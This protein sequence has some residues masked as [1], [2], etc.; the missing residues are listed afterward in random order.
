M[1]VL[2]EQEAL[3]PFVRFVTAVRDDVDGEGHGVIALESIRSAMSVRQFRDSQ[4]SW[5]GRT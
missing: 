1:P 3:C 2:I 5:L 4:E